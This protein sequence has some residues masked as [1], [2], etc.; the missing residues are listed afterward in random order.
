[1]FLPPVVSKV[2]GPARRADA[3]HAER[4]RQLAGLG[5]RSG[6][7]HV[8]SRT[9]AMPC[10][11]PLGLVK[12]PKE[13]SDLDYVMGTDGVRSGRSSAAAKASRRMHRRTRRRARRSRHRRRAA[14][15]RGRWRAGGRAAAPAAPPAADVGTTVQGLSL[16]KPPYGR[17]SPSISTKAS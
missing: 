10:I 3:R 15:G 4:R 17:S 12:P 2:G 14:R 8:H 13:F 16:V 9:R 1:M 7:A 11:A 5:V 6:T